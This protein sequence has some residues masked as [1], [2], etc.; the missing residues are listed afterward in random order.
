M[1]EAI[2]AQAELA[3]SG[4]PPGLLAI[5]SPGRL[6]GDWT[7]LNDTSAPPSESHVKSLLSRLNPGTELVTVLDGH[8][9]TLAWL[10]SVL[11]VRVRPLGVRKF[12][13]SGSLGEVYR[14]HG[15]DTDAIVDASR[16]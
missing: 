1:P 2:A 10:G 13:A 6:A 9:L 12:G 8:P 5:T 14:L 15:I 7:A 16:I 4:P 3:K 11:G